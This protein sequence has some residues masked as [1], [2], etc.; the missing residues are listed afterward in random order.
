SDDVLHSEDITPRPNT[1]HLRGYG[2]LQAPY[3]LV[4]GTI[5][6]VSI[7]GFQWSAIRPDRTADYEAVLHSEDVTPGANTFQLRGY[8]WLQAPYGLVEGTIRTVSISGF[9]RSAI[10][11]DRIADCDAVLHSEVVTRSANT[12]QLW[13]YSW[14]Q[15]SY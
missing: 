13:G 2:W 9:Q 7:S 15:A 11:P 8:G 14:L 1:F 12:F 6:T 10:R 3:G 5:R 4:E